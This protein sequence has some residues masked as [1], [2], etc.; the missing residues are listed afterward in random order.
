[1][2]KQ[3]AVTKNGERSVATLKKVTQMR[4]TKKMSWAQ[5]AAALEVAPRTARRMYDELNG[6]GA[7]H[8][9][10]EGKGGRTVAA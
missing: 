7:H 6:E 8:G 10:L 4:D 9:L 3:I 5:I 1:V 2:A